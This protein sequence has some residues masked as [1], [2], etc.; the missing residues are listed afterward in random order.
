MLRAGDPHEVKTGQ[1]DWELRRLLGR[2]RGNHS[3][4]YCFAAPVNRSGAT[5]DRPCEN[6]AGAAQIMLG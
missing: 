1:D 5:V 2:I 4:V 3:E 6:N